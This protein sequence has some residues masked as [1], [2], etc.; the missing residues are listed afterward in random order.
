MLVNPKP[1]EAGQSTHDK[2]YRTLRARIMH[3]EILPGKSLTLRGVG[4]EFDVSMTPAREAMRRLVA[5]GALSMSLSGRVSTPEL[6]NER[7]E[8]LAAIR[9]LLEVELASRALPRAH[10]ALIDR[11]QSINSGITEQVVKQDG[12]GYI[13]ANLEFHRT[14]YLRAQA[15]AMLAMAETVW[16]Q[17]GPT[18][19]ALYSRMRRNEPPHNHR[20]IIAALKA[21]DEPGLRLAVRMDVTHG[22]RHLAT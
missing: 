2:V 19:R 6:S 9:A 14:L 22:L 3:G 20:L 5:E 15:P 1:S 12:A 16:L 4:K 17:I 8:E 10:M 7:L 18:M 11:L 13:R 21:G